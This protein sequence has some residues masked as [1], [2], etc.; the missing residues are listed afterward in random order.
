MRSASSRSQSGDDTDFAPVVVVWHA[1]RS[2]AC[3]LG[4]ALSL[5]AVM[6]VILSL[7][8]ARRIAPSSW[9]RTGMHETRGT[10]MLVNALWPVTTMRVEHEEAH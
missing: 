4:D 8:N 1:A 2:H 7:R 3:G 6:E 10:I 5:T 9:A